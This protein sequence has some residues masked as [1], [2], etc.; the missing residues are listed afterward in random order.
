MYHCAEEVNLNCLDRVRGKTRGSIVNISSSVEFSAPC[1]QSIIL[2][3]FIFFL[4]IACI[5]LLLLATMCV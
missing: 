2:F 1:G 3:Y 4:I 5:C